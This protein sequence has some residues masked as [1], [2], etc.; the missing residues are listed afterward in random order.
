MLLLKTLRFLAGGLL[1]VLVLGRSALAQ[2]TPGAP[3]YE[4]GVV[5]I[6][7]D[8]AVYTAH[9]EA[10]L[11]DLLDDFVGDLPGGYGGFVGDLSDL[12][13]LL[14]L[15]G[16][17]PDLAL[18]LTPVDVVADLLWTNGFPSAAVIERLHSLRTEA[19]DVGEEVDPHYVIG[20]LK[21]LLQDEPLAG[22]LHAQ[23][24]FLYYPHQTS[25]AYATDL[26]TNPDPDR[27]AAWHLKAIQLR[28]AWDEVWDRAPARDPGAGPITIG[29]LDTGVNFS[30]QD[31]AGK[32]WHVTDCRDE[33]GDPTTCN[34]GRDFMGDT[35]DA[36]PTPGIIIPWALS[37]H[38]TW[39][40]G[41]AAG[42]FNNGYGSFGVAQDVE[43]VGIRVGD[44]VS[45]TTR[46][47]VQGMNFARHNELDI[48][49]VSLV[50]YHPYQSCAAYSLA[51]ANS[52]VVEYQALH[53]YSEGLFVM[54]AGNSPKESGGVDTIVLPAD[55][56]SDLSINGQQCWAGLDNVMQ[57]GG[58][59][60][61][62]VHNRER[63]WKDTPYG[64]AY[65]AHIDIATGAGDIPTVGGTESGT[66]FAAPQVAGV[67]ALMLMVKP[68]LTSSELKAK[69]RASADILEAFDGLD[70][71]GNVAA[72]EKNL[73][74][75]RRLNAYRAVKLALEETTTQIDPLPEIV[76]NTDAFTSSAPL[77]LREHGLGEAGGWELAHNDPVEVGWI[78]WAD[79]DAISSLIVRDG[80]TVEVFRHR[81]FQG[82][83][84]TYVG[85]QEVDLSGQALDN[86]ISSYKFYVTPAVAA[87]LVLREHGLSETG[88]WELVHN[89]PVEVGWIGWADNDAISSL[90]ISA[91]YT[92]EVF[93]HPDF[94]GEQQIYVGP[95]EVDL[96]G[97]TL[98]NQL[99]SYKFYVTPPLML[100]EHGLSEA[101]GWE[102]TQTGPVE[103]AEMEWEHNDAVSSL[104]IGAGYTVEV[105]SHAH[106]TG[107]R[108][109]YIGPQ[110]VDL[111]GHTLDNHISSYKLYAT[112]AS[113]QAAPLV[114]REQALDVAGGWEIVET[115]PVEVVEMEGTHNDAVSSL[116]IGAGYTVE[117]FRHA[118]FAGTR[119][120]Y[121]G[122]QSV[123]LAGQALD[124]QL[125]SY[126]LYATP[127]S[128][129]AAPLVLREQA[130]DVA[131]G[132]EIIE[133]VPVVLAWIGEAHNDAV[134]SLRI[135]DGYTV[136]V[137]SDW[138][139]EGTAQ[140][141]VGPQEVD[142]AAHGL[143]N[144]L[145]S[146][147]LY[148]T[149]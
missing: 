37:N 90:I 131:G 85:P 39:V 29:I 65:G 26:A 97:S 126:K 138:H 62:A 118:H 64:T 149:P 51:Q 30:D 38:G 121:V 10:L 119:L 54:A 61:D 74:G 82:G 110:T 15:V 96:S 127:A 52:L 109:I 114:L 13:L 111:A 86:Q 77:V 142:L 70:A 42:E 79:N 3:S 89:D 45:I 66:S 56:A 55:F 59:E 24:N 60:L 132:W 28:D 19:I 12:D 135:G 25:A 4:L 101:G 7:Y 98:D 130:L 133:I 6:Q 106:F 53:D 103:V 115:G 91:G 102:I 122:P 128:Y 134:S 34:G 18:P 93:R 44:N 104:L 2:P 95:Q 67:A 33:N 80:Y 49:N 105:F 36:D 35:H 81:D 63:I 14:S 68:T 100:R 1:A 147:K 46:D 99:S 143:N 116:L 75:G 41:V 40:A 124:N 145:S 83:Q 5:L 11:D 9:L 78:G 76:W 136:E 47:I 71:D 17:L 58:T 120:T 72:W 146:Y 48:I 57:V 16:E 94:Q 21:H 43:L 137:F 88:G 125:S 20:L 123:D 92:V 8:E 108:L 32:K 27:T 31:L 107:T 141:Y 144:Q 129:Q 73:A 148:A 69:L 84:Q 23:P 140:T 50:G 117:V 87:P 112:P 22:V 113:Y 139:F